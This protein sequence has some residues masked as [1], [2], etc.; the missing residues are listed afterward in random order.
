MVDV[1]THTWP[2]P[3][4]GAAATK[5]VAVLAGVTGGGVAIAAVLMRTSVRAAA[6]RRMGLLRDKLHTL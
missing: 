3:P 4:P 2:G 5:G 6:I 1:F